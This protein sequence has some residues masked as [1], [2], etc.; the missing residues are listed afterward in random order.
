MRSRQGVGIVGRQ[1]IKIT[2]TLHRPVIDGAFMCDGARWYVDDA[3]AV[4]VDRE[5]TGVGHLADD[6]SLNLPPATDI[7]EGID[8]LGCHHGAHA[9]LRLA[10]EDFL[11]REGGIA[12]QH[13]IEVHMHATL[14]IGREFARRAGDAGAP[15]ILNALD[16][17]G[18]QHVQ[19]A[20]NEQLL[21]EGIPDLDT[22]ALGRTIGVEGLTRQHR[23]ATDAIATGARAVQHDEVAD[24]LGGGQMNI[25]V[26]HRADAQGVDQR[27]AGVRRVED[28]LATDV[29]QPET[30]AV[31]TDARDDTGQDATGVG[32]VRGTEAQ[33][34]HHR[35]R[36]RTHRE[37][38]ADDAAD[39]R[40]RALIGLDVRRMIVRLDLEGDRPTITDVD[41]SG[42]FADAD[43]QLRPAALGLL[44]AE[45][46]QV[47]LGR[48]VGAVLTPHDRIHREFTRRR[49]AT[50][51]FADARIFVGLEAELGV[52]LRDLG[53]GLRA[54]DG[55]EAHEPILSRRIGESAFR[56][57]SSTV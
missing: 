28:D 48:L 44:V 31:T 38:V 29:G 8:V 36:A 53:G 24:T 43:E 45:L 51:D 30:V 17:T 34:V 20:L 50:E 5:A 52:G 47:H 37:D 3:I 27:V 46:A 33:R 2:R 6:D 10:H 13:P 4:P 22:G 42:V 19:R 18:V 57:P 26:P 25:L 55:I 56:A 16:Q 32:G 23:D 21:H 1:R 15:E 9:L 11:R 54:V 14:A 12:Q 40:G 49:P 39:P 7:H 41:D 35:Q